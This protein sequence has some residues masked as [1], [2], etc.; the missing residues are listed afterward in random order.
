[1]RPDYAAPATVDDAVRLLAEDPN[2][3]VIAGGTDLIPGIRS[4]SRTPSRVV[5]LRL[6]PLTDIA[7]EA[8]QI[9][10]GARVTF[11]DLLASDVIA[12][13][14]PA[15]AEAAAEVAGPPIR[16]R[17]TLG[18]NLVNASPAADS[19]PSLLVHDAMVVIVGPDGEREVALTEFFKGPGRTVLG[20][21]EILTEIRMPRPAGPTTSTFLKHGPRN[22]M[23]I[24]VVNAAVRVT[25]DGSGG[26]AEARIAL[27]SVAPTPIRAEAAERIVV[28][29]GLGADAVAAASSAAAEASSPIDDIR[30]TAGYRVQLVEVLVRRL[31]T[32]AAV[33][34][35]GSDA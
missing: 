11:T 2:G 16:N 15:L 17:A 22:A 30:G 1:M 35:E 29:E 24:S 14:F 3:A 7:V 32:A 20:P 8:G 10:I 26:A 9:R 33:T 21:G 23:A 13:E 12:S 4:G 28:A 5:D 27:G 18:G 31:L 6:L 19:A 25:G 34:L